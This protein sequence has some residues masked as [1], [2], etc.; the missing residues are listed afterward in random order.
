[1][2]KL[3]NHRTGQ[4]C[5][6]WN[7]CRA[8]RACRRGQVAPKCIRAPCVGLSPALARAARRAVARAA[9]PSQASATSP[10]HVAP[11][12]GARLGARRAEAKTDPRINQR[13]IIL[14][15]CAVLSL[16]SPLQSR[17]PAACRRHR[18]SAHPCCSARTLDDIGEPA[19]TISEARAA[20]GVTAASSAADIRRAFRAR[21]ME[22]HPDRSSAPDAPRRFRRLRSAFEICSNPGSAQAVWDRSSSWGGRASTSAAYEYR[23]PPPREEMSATERWG[24]W[25]LAIAFVGGQYASWAIFIQ[26]AA[27]GKAP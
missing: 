1:M 16:H 21:A 27:Q 9:A 23:P 11:R 8:P 19:L 12:V 17:W 26:L 18:C 22:C 14:V 10:R 13:R 25:G 20:L 3:C 7:G 4:S 24:R 6:L 5:G 2:A 15:A